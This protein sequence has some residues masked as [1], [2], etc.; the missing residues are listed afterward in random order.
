MDYL[1]SLDATGGTGTTTT[2]PDA[3][4]VDEGTPDIVTS[5]TADQPGDYPQTAEEV[6][7]YN[8]IFSSPQATS[9]LIGSTGDQPGDY[10]QQVIN[11]PDG[12]TTA[13]EF[14]GTQRVF[15]LDGSVTTVNPDGTS[16]TEVPAPAA[17]PSTGQTAGVNLGALA[18]SLLSS[19]QT[20]SAGGWSPSA[21][22]ALAGAGFLASRM[23][24][25]DAGKQMD[26]GSKTFDWNAQTPW[27]PRN[28][29]AYGQQF[30]NPKFAAQGGLMS[31]TPT[32]GDQSN[33]NR[34]SIDPTNSIQMYASGGLS[35]LGGYSDG[36]R[37]LKGPGDGMSDNIP[38]SISGKQPAR[39]AD[40][41]FVI[42]ADVVSHLGNGSTEAGS[43]VLYEMMNR[44]RKA[45]TGNPKQGKQI[46]P[47]KF[48]P[49]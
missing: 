45:R 16:T 22:A 43:R 21:L 12:T 15:N 25:A 28:A 14:D 9:E 35:T 1:S 32:V 19:G 20:G 23:G 6:K 29:V 46:N 10:P 27:M 44:V 39:L 49:R 31:I 47:K 8:D 18:Q 33:E 4:G 48:T 2:T 42:P 34:F 40:G 41:E 38:A 3:F 7:M 17:Q 30:V 24:G 26:I 5:P 36:G 11:N 13:V 37:L